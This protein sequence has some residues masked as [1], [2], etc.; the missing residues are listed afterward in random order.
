MH[1][2][3]LPAYTTALQEVLNNHIINRSSVYMTKS[4]NS[5]KSIAGAGLIGSSGSYDTDTH[6]DLKLLD[7][8]NL[9][10]TRV[11][12]SSYYDAPGGTTQFKIFQLV[13]TYIISKTEENPRQTYWLSAVTSLEHF[14]T[15]SNTG[16]SY[17]EY[18]SQK[19]GIRPYFLIG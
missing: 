1:T 6:T 5:D 17:F 19:A 4:V 7:E 12:S 3:V 16:C 2:I 8:I 9:Y 15:C 13:P 10:G 18:A 14:A 11:C